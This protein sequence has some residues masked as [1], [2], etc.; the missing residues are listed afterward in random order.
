MS[1]EILN[2]PL[3]GNSFNKVL[4]GNSPNDT[5]QETT[6]LKTPTELKQKTVRQI[7][8]T[9]YNGKPVAETKGFQIYSDDTILTG[10]I[11]EVVIYRSRFSEMIGEID[12]VLFA[13]KNGAF[14]L[15]RYMEALPQSNELILFLEINDDYN[16]NTIF[17]VVAGANL[18]N[19]KDIPFADILTFTRKHE[20]TVT[21]EDLKEL[22]EKGIY[23]NKAGLINWFF[24]L[25]DASVGRIFNFFTK[26]IFKE[27]E[28]FF[29]G[30]G[31]GIA[32]LKISEKGWNPNPKEGQYNPTFIPEAL[33]TELKKFYEQEASKNPYENLDGQK[34]V[35]SK[36]VRVLFEKIDDIKLHFK[37]LLKAAEPLFPDYIYI[38]INLALDSF[39]KQID[40]IEGY[41]SDPLTGMQ[42][43]IYKSFQIANAFLCGIYNSI[44]DIIAGIFSLI[45]FIFKAVYEIKNISDNK[46]EYGEIFLEL[47]E[48]MIGGIM[49]FD[50]AGFLYQSITFQIKNIIRLVKWIENTASG[51]TLEKAAYYYGYIIG[52]IIDIILETLLSGGTAAL[53]KLAK[54]VES[55]LLK[56]L[57]KIT[58]GIEKTVTF[59][60]DLLTKVL[61]FIQM[62]IREFK[63]G[64]KELFAKMNKLLDEVFGLG[65]DVASTPKTRAEERWNKKQERIK[66]KLD[67]KRNRNV[68]KSGGY[69]TENVTIKNISEDLAHSEIKIFEKNYSQNKIEHGKLFDNEGNNLSHLIIGDENSI[70]VKLSDILQARKKLRELGKNIGELIFTHNHPP[71]GSS[72]SYED[73]LLAIRYNIKEFRAINPDGSIFQLVRKQAFGINEQQI[74]TFQNEVTRTLNNNFKNLNPGSIEYQLKQADVAI[75][76]LGKKVEYTHYKP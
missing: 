73:I 26:Q 2:N 24:N 19:K 54:S 72:L 75:E 28:N 66:E 49:T 3:I 21:P 40:S 61:E 7:A 22:V 37:N 56:P 62:I 52:I 55:F 8:N 71:P 33:Y 69:Y 16:Y 47:M 59:T 36:I 4:G 31:D 17:R 9:Y 60:K 45:G 27:A 76:L 70:R 30:I 38:K 14:L 67:R 43:I 25:K 12:V 48:E 29:V 63:K 53:A 23:K 5:I 42:H 6:V 58:Q 15:Q 34:K 35:I 18:T 64:V 57:E 68:A 50:Y 20:V 13:S 74:M 1:L 10:D 11:E 46:V 51:F 44:I 65:E 32:G 41:L 39:F